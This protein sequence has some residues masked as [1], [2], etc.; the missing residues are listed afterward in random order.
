MAQFCERVAQ[1]AVT[2]VFIDRLEP[3]EVNRDVE[4][5]QE[6]LHHLCSEEVCI[7]ERHTFWQRADEIRFLDDQRHREE[8]R[9]LQRDVACQPMLLEDG[10]DNR[11]VLLQYDMRD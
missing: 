6:R 11:L 10:I 5:L 3:H 4:K 1:P 8:V 9:N 7:D 2:K